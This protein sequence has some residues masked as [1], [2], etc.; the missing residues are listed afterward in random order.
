MRLG[1]EAAASLSIHRS[2]NAQRAWL[3]TCSSFVLGRAQAAACH[4]K[5]N[6]RSLVCPDEFRAFD[7]LYDD[8]SIICRSNTGQTRCFPGS[9]SQMRA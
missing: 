5:Y 8:L 4:G 2:A 1:V 9:F 6:L 7:H 3:G